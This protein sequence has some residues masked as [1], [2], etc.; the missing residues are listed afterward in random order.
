M[1]NVVVQFNKKFNLDLKPKQFS[2]DLNN[3]VTNFP[4]FQ[5]QFTDCKVINLDEKGIISHFYIR[6][7]KCNLPR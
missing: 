2:T 4:Y 7:I 1:Q 3:T 6:L 5:E